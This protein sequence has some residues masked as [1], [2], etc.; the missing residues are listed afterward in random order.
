MLTR[1]KVVLALSLPFLC[2]ASLPVRAAGNYGG[3][4][5]MEWLADNRKMQLIGSFEYIGPDG[6]RWPG[7]AGTV[8]DGASIPQFFWSIT[9]TA[10]S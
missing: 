7:P 5:V 3:R 2:G 1:R 10:A 9:P 6:R 4:I 8:I